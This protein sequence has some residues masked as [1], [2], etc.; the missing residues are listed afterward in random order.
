MGDRIKIAFAF[1]PDGIV[2]KLRKHLKDD[3]IEVR[4]FNED[5]LE[6]IDEVLDCGLLVVDYSGDRGEAKRIIRKIRES[7]DVIRIL[8][9]V[10]VDQIS[11]LEKDFGLYDDYLHKPFK[12]EHLLY[13]VKLNIRLINL[14]KKGLSN[15]EHFNLLS[16]IA[17]K[18]ARA[19]NFYDAL[20]LVAKR[21]ADYLGVM[22]CSIMVVPDNEKEIIMVSTSDNDK[23][24]KLPLK[25]EKYPEVKEIIKQRRPLEISD[26]SR[27]AI[28]KD[29]N[30]TLRE[31]GIKYIC[32]IPI[33]DI[34]EFL[35]VIF[36]RDN[37][38]KSLPALE[39]DFLS[40]VGE[41]MG[42][43]F[44]NS[45]FLNEVKSTTR[46]LASEIESM[47]YTL[48]RL[49]EDRDFLNDLIQDAIEGIIITNL[50]GQILVFN[51]TT[52]KV[53]GYSSLEVV[54]KMKIQELLP[55]DYSE[56]I[57]DEF[58][59]KRF[60]SK[61]TIS[62]GKKLFVSKKREAIPVMVTARIVGRSQDFGGIIWQFIDMRELINAQEK[63]AELTENLEIA[64]KKAF[65]AA[66]AGTAAHEMNQ[67]LQSIMGYVE[68][69]T[70]RA[71]EGTIEYKY[72]QTINQ[73]CERMAQ[74]IKNIANI[75]TYKTK[76]YVGS[77]KI[78]D[79]EDDEGE[80]E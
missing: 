1:I 33:N 74:I 46:N 68:L 34:N 29:F 45:R 2:D 43:F 17:N 66:L 42:I 6:R 8:I 11:I 37:R 23:L 26:V 13:K 32:L 65:T 60:G 70:K 52:E 27:S 7:S 53:L 56:D 18:L 69:L 58:N 12:P 73:E 28:L 49:R 79:I 75:T 21:I 76:E 61:A 4:V 36:V 50:D 39:L 51:K 19:E 24:F 10:P 14:F 47:E 78:I 20:H 15:V 38:E 5:I 72:L 62:M 35:G 57:I 64:R 71:K 40:L 16:D 55:Q 22:R 54:E 9:I 3:D 63:L 41:I 31:A 80:K 77:T 44:N 59:T 25:L 67:P 48:S 30:K